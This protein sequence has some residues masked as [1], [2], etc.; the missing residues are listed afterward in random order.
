MDC[1]TTAPPCILFRLR[2]VLIFFVPSFVAF[3][4]A[5]ADYMTCIE[6]PYIQ[7]CGSAAGAFVCS[8]DRIFTH[9]INPMLVYLQITDNI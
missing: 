6:L 3:Y 2:G 9:V 1:D 5:I 8:G 7:H 4:R